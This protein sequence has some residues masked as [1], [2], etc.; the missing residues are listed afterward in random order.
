MSLSCFHIY[1]DEINDVVVSKII[2]KMIDLNDPLIFFDATK[3]IID[4]LVNNKCMKLFYDFSLTGILIGFEMEYYFVK[5]IEKLFQYPEGTKVVVYE[6]P[7]FNSE[8][9]EFVLK[10]FIEDGIDYIKFYGDYEAAM[11][12]LNNK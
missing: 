8:K 12:W 1:Y 6:G 2:D 9:W 4:L 10:I 5:N 3:K 11:V 7:H